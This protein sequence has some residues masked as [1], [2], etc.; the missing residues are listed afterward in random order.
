[1]YMALRMLVKD[2]PAWVYFG[3]AEEVIAFFFIKENTDN[4]KV[5]LAL[6]MKQWKIKY[7]CGVFFVLLQMKYF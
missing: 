7:Y 1:M 5:V 6:Q 3:G 4:Q 2:F